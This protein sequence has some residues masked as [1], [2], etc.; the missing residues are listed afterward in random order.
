MSIDAMAMKM[1]RHV[2]QANRALDALHGELS[3]VSFGGDA[4][5]VEHANRWIA[6]IIDSGVDRHPGNPVI[7]HIAEDLK[8]DYLRKITAWSAMLRRR[9][10]AD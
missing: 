8:R 9:P 10:D 2:E 6:R 4:R 1:S 5:S 7:R 3:L